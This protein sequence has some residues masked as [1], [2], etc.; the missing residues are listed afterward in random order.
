MG[1]GIDATFIGQNNDQKGTWKQQQNEEENSHSKKN[2]N[3]NNKKAHLFLTIKILWTPNLL[4]GLYH[5]YT[6]KA[7]KEPFNLRNIVCNIFPISHFK[8]LP[9]TLESGGYTICTEVKAKTAEERRGAYNTY[10]WI[11]RQ[12]K[13]AIVNNICL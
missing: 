13:S 11:W 3:N 12:I 4:L 10:H 5:S 2:N 1:R 8:G 7:Q 9:F 6:R